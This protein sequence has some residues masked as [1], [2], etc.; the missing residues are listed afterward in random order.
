VS[1][2]FQKSWLHGLQD[3][4][5]WNEEK[6]HFFTLQIKVSKFWIFLAQNFSTK[7]SWDLWYYVRKLSW[8]FIKNKNP[9]KYLLLIVKKSLSRKAHVMREKKIANNANMELKNVNMNGENVV[10]SNV[11]HKFLGKKD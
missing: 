1:K 8:G 9:K 4:S 5:I 10:S 2:K 7:K 11:N 3:Y 6:I